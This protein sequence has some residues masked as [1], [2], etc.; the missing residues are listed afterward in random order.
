MIFWDI[1][2]N[3]VAVRYRCRTSRLRLVLSQFFQDRRLPC[4]N[5]SQGCRIARRSGWHGRRHSRS[6]RCRNDRFHRN[7]R[8][9]RSRSDN[10]C[11]SSNRRR[12]GRSG[13]LYD[14]SRLDRMRNHRLSCP[15]FMTATSHLPGDAGVD[16]IFTAAHTAADRQDGRI[17]GMII[18][19]NSHGIGVMI[20]AVVVLQR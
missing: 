20:A 11:Q 10:R 7:W 18:S 6:R 14:R 1:W 8:S 2:E 12:A 4:Q 5:L 9:D 3:I 19:P 16:H 13:L 15:L 17:I